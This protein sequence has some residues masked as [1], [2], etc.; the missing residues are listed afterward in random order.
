MDGYRNRTLP[1]WQKNQCQYVFIFGSV[2]YK[3][4]ETK[5]L[6]WIVKMHKFLR[7]ATY[8]GEPTQEAG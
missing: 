6:V 7:T 3:N 5:R 2:F 8:L 1:S 4:I